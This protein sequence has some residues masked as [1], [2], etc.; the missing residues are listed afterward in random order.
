[1][2]IKE[3]IIEESAAMFA[4]YGLKSVR[5]DDIASQMG[6]SKRTIYELFG[7]KENLI[8]SALMHFFHKKEAHDKVCAE[9]AENV[10]EALLRNMAASEEVIQQGVSVMA[11]L[12]KFYPQIHRRIVEESYESGTRHMRELIDRGIDE[13]LF[14]R[15]VNPDML[16]TFFVELMDTIFNR[17]NAIT[18]PKDYTIAEMLRF[19]MVFFVR[20]MSTPEGIRMVDQYLIEKSILNNN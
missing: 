9:G 15:Y 3:R 5:M 2:S 18:P 8:T 13:G 20:G 14:V 12:R 16:I 6:I 19:S 4:T 11:D 1:M 17:F 10:I 7:D